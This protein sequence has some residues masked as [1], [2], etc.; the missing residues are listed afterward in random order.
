[1]SGIYIHIPFCKQACHYCDFHF[2]TT[3]KEYRSSLI[4][5]MCSELQTRKHNEPIKTIYF[6][7]GT[8]SLLEGSEIDLILKT[9]KENYKVDTHCEITLEGNPD[10]LNA[11][12]LQMLYTKGIHRLSI[13]IQAFQDELLT[14]MNRAH[15]SKEA[16]DC[17][18]KAKKIGFKEIS[19]DL[20]YGIPGLTLKQWKENLRVA[21]KMPIDHLS[22][23]HLTIEPKTVFSKWKEKNKL[24]ITE[25]GE[26]LAQ[27]QILQEMAKDNGLEHYEI[28]N[29]CRDGL[30]SKHNTSY[31]E[32]KNYLG[33]G[34]GAHSLRNGIRRWNISNNTLYI[35]YIQNNLDYHESEVLT[36][37]S[38][39]NELIM[40]KLRLIQDGV[41]K[42][43]IQDVDEK[44]WIHFKKEIQPFLL[45]GQVEQL[46]NRYRLTAK[47][48]FIA[49]HIIESLFYI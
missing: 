45:S 17:V 39:Y 3:F 35:K 43:D 18:Q 27:F 16:I 20:I 37:D 38:I 49:D 21:L 31:W 36:K 23:Y 33:I 41:K 29:F 5:A 2:S 6:G 4:E 1:M 26:S 25:E 13:G 48:I 30:R 28:S 14:F 47:G 8:P 10:D 22:A 11:S 7:G 32:G 9:V 24:P 42:H 46:S 34:P 44:Y 40:V 19:I 15:N 12:Y